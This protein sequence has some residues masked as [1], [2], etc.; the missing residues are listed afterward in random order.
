MWLRRA[1]YCV[2][3]KCLNS[4]TEKLCIV[5]NTN[6]WTQIL[7]SIM[8]NTKP[9]TIV[10]TRSR[11]PSRHNVHCILVC[12]VKYVTM[13]RIVTML[14]FCW[15][16]LYKLSQMH[17]QFTKLLGIQAYF[18]R[19]LNLRVFWIFFFTKRH[20]KWKPWIPKSLSPSNRVEFHASQRDII[21]WLT[22]VGPCNAR[23]GWGSHYQSS[24]PC[25]PG[26]LVGNTT[27]GTEC[28]TSAGTTK[29]CLKV[30][31]LSDN[32]KKRVVLQK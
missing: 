27:P 13:K 28:I 1:L 16:G 11:T 14:A 20:K 17:Y 29:I 10:I 21:H 30:S 3:H 32:T 4:N 23:W 15:R 22:L 18:E 19:F 31:F 9:N 24:N 2:K 7:K 8:W 5:S 12:C 26:I 6:T 25:G